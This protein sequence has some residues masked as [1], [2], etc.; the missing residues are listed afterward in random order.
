MIKLNWTSFNFSSHTVWLVYRS[1]WM[2]LKL[3]SNWE[4]TLFPKA[5]IIPLDHHITT[6]I[7]CLSVL[8]YC[9]MFI[10]NKIKVASA[11]G[12]KSRQGQKMVKWGRVFCRNNFKEST[13][14][15]KYIFTTNK[16][17]FNQ[18]LLP[19]EKMV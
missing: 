8:N 13:K 1:F 7:E 2:K 17:G 3:S 18:F 15:N 5:D 4:R 19:K 14:L 10:R 11:W 6:F 12:L 16:S 9:S